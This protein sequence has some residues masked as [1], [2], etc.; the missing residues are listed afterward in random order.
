MNWQTHFFGQKARSDVSIIAT[1]T[2][3]I[4]NSAGSTSEA[5]KED[6]ITLFTPDPVVGFGAFSAAS[7]GSALDNSQLFVIEG[8]S[9]YIEN[10][11][12]NTS[13]ADVT[14]TVTWGDG[15]TDSIADDDAAGGVNGGR[16]E[17][18]WADGSNTG[19]GMDTLELELTSHSTSD[20]DILPVS[21]QVPIKVYDDSPVDPDGLDSKTLTEI[22]SVGEDGKTIQKVNVKEKFVGSYQIMF[23]FPLGLNSD[24]E[25][26]LKFSSNVQQF[27]ELGCKVVG[28]TNESPLAVRRWMEKDT[29]SVKMT[30]TAK[31][32]LTMAP[33][34]TQY[35]H[36][37]PIIIWQSPDLKVL[38]CSFW[39]EQSRF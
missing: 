3:A 34:V 37:V 36:E 29:E 31:M 10:T 2:S 12:T 6:Y 22:P 20:P 23:F 9:I 17:H 18:T 28:V 33:R 21:I 4:V 11:T 1:N 24:S 30:A 39:S 26:V 25:E 7:G 19:T 27:G 35:A 16:L 8:Q 15:N 5:T 38:I 32:F 14:Y 13:N